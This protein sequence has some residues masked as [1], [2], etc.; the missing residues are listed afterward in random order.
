MKIDNNTETYAVKYPVKRR[1]TVTSVFQNSKNKRQKLNDNACTETQNH[2]NA[3]GTPQGV[4]SDG[5]LSANIDGSQRLNDF[6]DPISASETPQRVFGGENSSY[7][8]DVAQ[9]VD[10]SRLRHTTSGPSAS[11]RQATWTPHTASTPVKIGRVDTN[12]RNSGS[13]SDQLTLPLLPSDPFDGLVD[14]IDFDDDWLGSFP[15][16]KY[17][18]C[19]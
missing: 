15:R 12:K 13:T 14:G 8:R 2:F 16:R 18:I 1:N 10:L 6:T 17:L 3:V 9:M 11:E 5:S 4:I 19:L 7:I